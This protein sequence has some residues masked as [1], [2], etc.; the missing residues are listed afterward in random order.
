MNFNDLY[1]K[2]KSLDEGVVEPKDQLQGGAG[3]SDECGSMAANDTP[4][5]GEQPVEE[6]GMDMPGDMVHPPKQ[7][8]SVTMNVSMNGSGA[9]GIKDLMQILRNIESGASHD[10]DSADK[11]LG[12]DKD[13]AFGEEQATGGFDQASTSPSTVTLD[14]DSVTQTGNDLAS[15][16]GNEVEKVNGG[17]NPYTNI[18]EGL[19]RR[20]YDL[21]TEIKSR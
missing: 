7:S 1:K 13:I 16:G 10:D 19:Q 15:H 3:A 20:L 9:G 4:L 6:C 5:M 11:L 17:G 14:I 12:S 8:D 18:G 21:Y 2:I